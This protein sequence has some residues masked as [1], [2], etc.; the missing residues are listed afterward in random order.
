MPNDQEPIGMPSVHDA[1]E[2]DH[3]FS[4][5]AQNIIKLHLEKNVEILEK[6]HGDVPKKLTSHLKPVTDQ[7][8]VCIVGAGVADSIQNPRV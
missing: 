7:E 1:H 2:W 6:I 8:P 5:R 4:I 3:I